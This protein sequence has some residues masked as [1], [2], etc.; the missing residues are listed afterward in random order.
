MGIIGNERVDRAAGRATQKSE[1]D[2]GVSKHTDLK[3][4]KSIDLLWQEEWSNIDN[5][6][7]SIKNTIRPWQLGSEIERRDK[8]K[9]HRLRIGHNALTHKHLLL[10]EEPPICELCRQLLTVEHMICSCV[11]LQPLRD[12]C[13]LRGGLELIL[14]NRERMGDV[15]NFLRTAGF[16]KEI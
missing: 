10:G 9:I 8:I 7:R 1:T 2:M 14:N 5:Q 3:K 12:I 13:G 4:K 11:A 15:L 6:L 16:Y